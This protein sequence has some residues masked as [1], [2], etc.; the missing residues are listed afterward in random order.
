MN[1]YGSF[2]NLQTSSILWASCE[3]VEQ[4]NLYTLLEEYTGTLSSLFMDSVFANL[5]TH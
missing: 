5:L 3:N 1:F 4:R 2:P